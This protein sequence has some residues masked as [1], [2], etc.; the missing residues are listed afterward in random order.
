MRKYR[1]KSLLQFFN[2]ASS[3]EIKS[4]IELLFKRTTGAVKFMLY[5]TFSIKFNNFE[6]FY[7]CAIAYN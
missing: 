3:F 2:V 5:L 4:Q 1:G 7:L 6:K